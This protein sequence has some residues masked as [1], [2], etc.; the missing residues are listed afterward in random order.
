[1]LEKEDNHETLPT[2]LSLVF[3][4]PLKEH[5]VVIRVLTCLF[6]VYSVYRLLQAVGMSRYSQSYIQKPSGRLPGN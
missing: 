2:Q 6:M 4:L 5:F 1:M 3:P